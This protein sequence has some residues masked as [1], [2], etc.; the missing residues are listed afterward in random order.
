M[1][2]R[3]TIFSLLL[4]AAFPLTGLADDTTGKPTK[5]EVKSWLRDLNHD[6]FERRENAVK[7]LIGAGRPVVVLLT[8]VAI[9]G[10]LEESSQALKILAALLRSA[11]PTTVKSTEAALREIAES[12]NVPAA[13]TATFLLRRSKRL[14]AMRKLAGEVKMSQI[15]G[16]RKISV[17][18]VKNVSYR[19]SDPTR[20]HLDGTFWIWG[21]KGRPVAF[22]ELWTN[23]GAETIWYFGLI[24]LSRKPLSADL[25]AGDPWQPSKTDAKFV[26]F[27]T[28]HKPAEDS[29]IRRT[30]LKELAGRFKAFEIGDPER[31]QDPLEIRSDPVYRY[32]NGDNGP[33]EGG[34]FLI[35]HRGNPEIVL[36][37][38][39][40]KTKKGTAVWQY[41][42]LRASSAELHVQLDGKEVWS[43]KGAVPISGRPNA[44][45]RI[46]RRIVG[47]R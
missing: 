30:Q 42:L 21:E 1:C 5:A 43:R 24:S 35:C 2:R 13:K 16:K 45:Y 34:V 47:M 27:E 39:A 36:L 14:R 32:K 15:S 28:A 12:K 33:L 26:R 9:E 4:V 25:G 46:R 41:A 31:K 8:K 6:K 29:S 23:K 44:P 38:E 40:V 22:A 20:T 10:S 18:M 11:D 19:F 7:Q 17:R 37:V 3:S